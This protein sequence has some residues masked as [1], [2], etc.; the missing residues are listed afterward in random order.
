MVFHLYNSGTHFRQM[1]RVLVRLTVVAIQTGTFCA[2]FAL[3][4]LFSFRKTSEIAIL[5]IDI[6]LLPQAQCQAVI[7][8][9]YLVFRLA[10]F[11]QT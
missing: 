7:F 2:I 1:N 4:D 6:A 11:T 9:A 5:F 3:G 8:M 10:A